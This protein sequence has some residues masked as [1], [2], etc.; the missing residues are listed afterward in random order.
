MIVYTSLLFRENSMFKNSIPFIDKITF[1]NTTVAGAIAVCQSFIHSGINVGADTRRTF[2]DLHGLTDISGSMGFKV[3]VKNGVPCI[4]FTEFNRTGTVISQRVPFT[5]AE[6]ETKKITR[7]DLC[8]F[9]VAMQEDGCLLSDEAFAILK[10]SVPASGDSA[11]YHLHIDGT[12]ILPSVPKMNLEKT[13]TE[14]LIDDEPK[15]GSP[16]ME[17]DQTPTPSGIAEIDNHGHVTFTMDVGPGSTGQGHLDFLSKTGLD[18]PVS[19]QSKVNFIS[20]LASTVKGSYVFSVL[21][22]AIMDAE[23]KLS[24]NK[25]PVDNSVGQEEPKDKY[26]YLSNLNIQGIDTIILQPGRAIEGMAQLEK[27]SKGGLYVNLG[28]CG[29][30][31]YL[32]KGYTEVFG[33]YVITTHDG[34]VVGIE[35]KPLPVKGPVCSCNH[36]IDNKTHSGWQDDYKGTA[37]KNQNIPETKGTAKPS[38]ADRVIEFTGAGMNLIYILDELMAYYTIVRGY[39]DCRRRILDLTHSGRFYHISLTVKNNGIDYIKYSVLNK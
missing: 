33:E 21:N 16:Q 19:V 7:I 12:R 30:M 5:V 9:L 39:S 6:I 38:S 37:V 17:N 23:F 35:F 8:D 14:E 2:I 29:H 34:D 25:F 18:V 24:P 10:D 13:V 15:T 27:L 11:I 3:E 28:M 4:N 20:Q 32:S 31:Y 26:N 1:H 22:R 36:G